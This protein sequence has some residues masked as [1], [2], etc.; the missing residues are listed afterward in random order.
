VVWAATGPEAVAIATTAAPAKRSRVRMSISSRRA[1]PRPETQSPGM[2]NMQ[3]HDEKG[4]AGHA[5]PVDRH[6]PAV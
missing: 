2:E 4:Y 6:G 1:W 3:R 5:S